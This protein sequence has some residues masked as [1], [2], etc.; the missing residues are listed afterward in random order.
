MINL[1]ET[2]LNK[3]NSTLR[4]R[5]LKV[6]CFSNSKNIF[7]YFKSTAFLITNLLVSVNL[8]SQQIKVTSDFGFLGGINI[9]KRLS[10]DLE[11]NL[12]Q[13][14]RFYSNA[15]K[16]DD[17]C[18]DMGGKYKMNKN[19]KLG[20]NLRYT[21]DSKL[22]KD[23][24]DN[25]RYNF[26][27]HYNWNISDRLTFCNRLRYQHEFENLFTESRSTNMHYATIRNRVKFN[28]KVSNRHEGY[29]SA[30]LFRLKETFREA[31]FNKVRFFLGDEFNS[32]KGKFS[33]SIGYDQEI[34][35]TY[36]LSFLFLKTIYTLKL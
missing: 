11:V 3:Q 32:E 35:S 14:L 5:L 27:L 16:F 36:P 33:L 6:C 10:K 26:D 12:E 30:E 21:Y 13:Q 1:S 8:Y 31:Y 15:T 20:A 17:Y 19:F 22:W 34:N 28:Y 25:Y 2:V 23:K 4:R 18:I 9:E 7:P 24:V 29:F